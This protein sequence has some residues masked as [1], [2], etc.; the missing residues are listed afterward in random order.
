MDV[1]WDLA[2]LTLYPGFALSVLAIWRGLKIPKIHP[3]ITVPINF[4][5]VAGL[6]L[7][8]VGSVIEIVALVWIELYQSFFVSVF[9]VGLLTVTLGMVIG[10]TIEFGLMR[11]GMVFASSLRRWLTLISVVLMFGSIWLAA[12]GFFLHLATLLQN[13]FANLAA[14]TL[15]ALVAT[16][17]LV[18]TK[19]VLPG[20][21]AALS[22]GVVFTS[23]S[24]FFVVGVAKGSL[25]VP[26]G[27][28]TMPLFDVVIL[29]ARRVMS[30][31][32]AGFVASFAIGWFFWATYFPF[33]STLFPWSSSPQ[34]QL[35]AVVL[36]SLAGALLGN[37]VFAGL[38]SA[39]LGAVVD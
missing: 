21:G 1:W 23:V 4:V 13:P 32:R 30:M 38:T 20:F 25:Y 18:P 8:A 16:L 22:I 26:W 2:P 6:K 7:A 33:T 31:T 36:G 29:G 10:L 17:V 3:A 11:R 34:L 9:T 15:L 24:Y 39:V 5:N 27:L 28:L 19:R 14:A 35:V 12:A 37:A